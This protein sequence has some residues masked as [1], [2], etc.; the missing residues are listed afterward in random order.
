MLTTVYKMKEYPQ[1]ARPR[2]RMEMLGAEKLSDQ[3]LL[4]ILL[5]TG[6][7]EGS[8]LDLAEQ[9]LQRY[10]GLT[11]LQQ[12]TLAELMEQKGI[13]TAKATTI[14]AAVELGK[15]ISTSVNGYRPVIEGSADAARILQGRM[16]GLDREH[17][18]VLFLNPKH[19]VLGMETVSIG[20]LSSSL[21]HPRE[22]FKQAIKRSASAVILAHNH[23]SGSCEPSKEDLQVTKRLKDVGELVGIEVIDHL[24]IGEDKYYS[25]CENDLL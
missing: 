25:F 18:F 6:S 7:R 24:I 15:R 8:A 9:L 13:G 3:E 2:E 10:Q 23:P 1:H 5:S 12:A 17:F 21:V 14:A 11:G 20:T 19:A 4:A 16:R 22:V